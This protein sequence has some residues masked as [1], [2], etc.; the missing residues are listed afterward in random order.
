MG[1]KKGEGCETPLR[2]IILANFYKSVI[3]PRFRLEKRLQTGLGTPKDQR[4]NVMCALVGIDRLQVDHMTD[5]VEFQ[6]D[7]VSAMH[8]AG[9]T[10]NLQRL[11]TVVAFDNR[12]HFRRRIGFVHQAPDPQASLQTQSDFGLH[13][14]ELQLEQLSVGQRAAKLMPIKAILACGMPAGLSGPHGAP[15]NAM[16]ARFRQPKGP[17]KP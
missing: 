10:R 9:V 14:C 8:I 15:A 4:M 2:L 17:F 5:D 6:A 7:T 11:A 13:I 12:N 3:W 16:R 1:M